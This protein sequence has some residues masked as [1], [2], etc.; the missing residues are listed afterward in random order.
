MANFYEDL[1]NKTVIPLLEQFGKTIEMQ[2]KT[3]S[4]Y[5]PVTGKYGDD[6]FVKFAEGLAVQT[7]YSNKDI[8]GKLIK[9]GDKELICA[10]TTNLSIELKADDRIIMDGVTW[11]VVNVGEVKPGNVRL[12][13]KGVQLRK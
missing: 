4:V 12:L 11:N 13:Y 8:D 10:Q 3:N 6:T 2:N 1:K 7:V 5:D 9:Q